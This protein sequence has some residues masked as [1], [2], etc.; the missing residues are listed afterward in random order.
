MV[1][2]PDQ[3]MQS[4][5]SPSPGQKVSFLYEK[6]GNKAG[7]YDPIRQHEP[8]ASPSAATYYL[9]LDMAIQIGFPVQIGGKKMGRILNHRFSMA[10]IFVILLL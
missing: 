3:Q 9:V 1:G 2:V 10:A 5:A 6:V 7:D 8:S 4:S